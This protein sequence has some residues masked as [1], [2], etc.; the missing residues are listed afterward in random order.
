M[1]KRALAQVRKTNKQKQKLKRKNEKMA[2]RALA[3]VRK[4]NKQKQKLK[5]KNKKIAKR[6]LT[7]ASSIYS[8][9]LTHK[10]FNYI[11]FYSE[12]KFYIQEYN[13]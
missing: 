4:A 9:M 2:K 6:A 10:N 5:S 1:A 13:S 11:V 12:S 7:Q 3:Q 8:E